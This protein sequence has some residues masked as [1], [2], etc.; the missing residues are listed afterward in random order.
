MIWLRRFSLLLFLLPSLL[1]AQKPLRVQYGL[2]RAHELKP[3][4]RTIPMAGVR[5]GFNQLR[6]TLQVSVTGDVMRAE[7]SGADGEMKFRPALQT[8]VT[9]WKFRPFEV[10]GK[11][12][13]AEVEEYIDLVPPERLPKVHVQ[14]PQVRSDSKI[15]IS[16]SRSGC[17]GSCPSYTVTLSDGGVAFDGG[18]FTVASGKHTAPLEPAVLRALAERFVAADFYSFDEEYMALVTDNPSKTLS[19]SI[20]GLEKKVVDYVGAWV[21]MPAVISE[22][23]DA[24]DEAARTDRWVNGASG[25]VTALRAERYDFRTYEAQAMLKEAITHRQTET[26][27]HMLKAGVQLRPLPAPKPKDEYEGI[28]FKHEGWLTVSAS[29]AAMLRL[30]MDAGASKDDATDKALALRVAAHD[31]SVASFRELVAYGADPHADLSK[32][33]VTEKGG[34]MELQGPGSG[35]YLIEAASSGNPEMVREVLRHR[36]LLEAKDRRGRTA[37]FAAGDYRS[38]DE[39]GAR[40]QCVRLLIDAGAKVNATDNEGNT[41]LHETFQT[42]VEDALIALGANVN[43]QRRRRDANLHDL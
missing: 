11:P 37:L 12:A 19:I 1:R 41:P 5:S 9:Q 16:L 36:P 15:V 31:G 28:P 2:A 24:V 40:V 34:G 18:G 3:H 6:L 22:L 20:D 30:L 43:A 42:D 21:G 17:Y 23:E 4:R 39:D 8:E 14:A 33:V 13:V 38:S 25:L 10:P 26:A 29:D 27:T 7:A 35:S 32:R